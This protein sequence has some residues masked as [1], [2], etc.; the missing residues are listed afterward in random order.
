M[1]RVIQGF[2]EEMRLPL[3]PASAA[4]KAAVDAALEIAGLI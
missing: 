3:V 1:T 2:P 4:S